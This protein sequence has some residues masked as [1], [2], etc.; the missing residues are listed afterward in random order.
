MQE[1]FPVSDFFS[2]I[3]TTLANFSGDQWLALLFAV[4]AFSVA[5]KIVQEGVSIVMTIVGILLVLYF[6]APD[7]Y[8]SVIQAIDGFVSSL[9]A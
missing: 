1:V 3:A 7:V 9:T 4:V 5:K 6:L 8:S 2:T